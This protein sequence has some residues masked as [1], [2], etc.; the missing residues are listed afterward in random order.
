MMRLQVVQDGDGIPQVV[1]ADG[2]V[3]D[4]AKVIEIRHEVGKPV[5]VTFT[6]IDM[7]ATMA[8]LGRKL[9]KRE[10]VPGLVDPPSEAVS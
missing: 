8:M 3:V 6:F 10:D 9:V 2:E 1:T 4:G 7:P 5:L